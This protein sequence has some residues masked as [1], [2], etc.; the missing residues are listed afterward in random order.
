MGP[1]ASAPIPSGYTFG[2]EI[3]VNIFGFKHGSL[4]QMVHDRAEIEGE[5]EAF[6]QLSTYLKT[7]GRLSPGWG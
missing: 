1:W 7:A 4:V 2:V 6:H 5:E 3:E